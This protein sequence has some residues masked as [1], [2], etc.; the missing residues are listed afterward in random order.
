[1]Y[2]VAKLLCSPNLCQQIITG[3]ADIVQTATA[4]VTAMQADPDH[5]TTVADATLVANAF[6]EVCLARPLVAVRVLT[7]TFAIRPCSPGPPQ[8]SDWQGWALPD[9][10]PHWRACRAYPPPSRGHCRRK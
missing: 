10:S 4:S 2:C 5:M 1:M 9:G 3:F 8:H 7:R 6:R